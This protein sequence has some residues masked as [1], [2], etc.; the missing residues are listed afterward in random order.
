MRNTA[1]LL[2]C[3]RYTFQFFHH[4]SIR[5]SDKAIP[6]CFEQARAGLV[7]L[8]LTGFSVGVAVDLN[9]EPSAGTVEVGDEPAEQDVLTPDVQAEGMLSHPAPQK[10]LG[11]SERMPKVSR[12]LE[13]ARRNAKTRALRL[14][15][16]HFLSP[17]IPIEIVY[18][19]PTLPLKGGG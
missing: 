17:S 18:P 5:E 7:V 14:V 16:G 11:G 15:P 4:I 8:G 10:L 1:R 13:D 6:A 3:T 19:H 9:A 12:A 2:D